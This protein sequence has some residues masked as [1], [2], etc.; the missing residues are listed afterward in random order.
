MADRAKTSS[1][2]R[3]TCPLRPGLTR[4]ARKSRPIKDAR[5]LRYD[6]FLS[7]D[8]TERGVGE[9]C[10]DTDGLLEHA[11]QVAET[12]VKP[13]QDFADGRIMT[14]CREPLLAFAALMKALPHTVT[15]TRY[16][17]NS[18]IGGC[19]RGLLAPGQWAVRQ[20]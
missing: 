1:R 19:K 4:T 11:R 3:V 13:F 14:L 6:W 17:F 9:G 5:T 18:R 7:D 2:L 12:R 16:S 10:V 8:Q 20:S 15:F